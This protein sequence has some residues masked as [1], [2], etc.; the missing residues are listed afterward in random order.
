M[1]QSANAGTPGTSGGT[2]EGPAGPTSGPVKIANQGAAHIQPGASHP[3]YNSN[4]PTSGWHYDTP[5]LPGVY[6]EPIVD[7]TLI[8]N[9]EHGYVIISY[10]CSLLEGIGCDEL[11]TNLKSLFDLKR[12]WKI[13]V[14]PR[15]A[16]DTGIALTAW[17][18]ID[19]FNNYDQGRIENFITQ[20]RDQGPEKTQS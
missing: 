8:H 9:L 17:D 13:I 10:N 2:T 6:D 12:G 5:A 1:P 16:L 3:A 11:K 14:V 7:E 15:P 4:P 20:F 18:N 19:K